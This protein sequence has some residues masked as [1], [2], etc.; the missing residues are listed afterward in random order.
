MEQKKILVADDNENIREALTYLLEDEGYQ[1]WL[2]KDGAE[3]ITKVREFRPDILFLD[4][5]MPEINGYDVCRA[6]K[7][8]PILKNTYVIMLTAK[9][10]VAEQERGKEVGADEYIVKPF[11]PME[12]LT[13]I[14]NILVK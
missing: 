13:K 1:L 11:S 3:T 6:I 2:A 9:G 12:I 4:I 10:Q 8:D 5:M 14:K 7:S